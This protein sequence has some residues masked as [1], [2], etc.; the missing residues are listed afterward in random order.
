M[1]NQYRSLFHDLFVEMM[2]NG[3]VTINI[4]SLKKQKKYTKKRKRLTIKQYKAIYKSSPN[5]LQVAMDLSL[6]TSQGRNEIVNLKYNDLID[7]FIRITRCKTQKYDSSRVEIPI[8]DKLRDIITLSF[9]D[10]A[11]PFIVHKKPSKITQARLL[12]SDVNQVTPEQITREF[13]LV[14]DSLEMFEN[15]EP[16]KRPTFHEIRALSIFLGEK[17]G[18]DMKARACHSDRKMTERYIRGHELEFNRVENIE[19]EL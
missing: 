11:S 8:S 14:R 7:G 16:S 18:F 6:Q 17:S 19:I 12:L 4:A 3:I 15:I 10:I 13:K 5:W 2:D 1:F 9:N